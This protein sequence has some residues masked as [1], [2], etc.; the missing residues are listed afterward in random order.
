M[1]VKFPESFLDDMREQGRV[2]SDSGAP[3]LP[4]DEPGGKHKAPAQREHKIQEALFETAAYKEG[5][6][7]ALKLLYAVPNGQ[8]RR[9]QR[10]EPGL[11]S[12]VPDVALP[13]PRPGTDGRLYHGLYLELKR[14]GGRVRPEQRTWLERLR[15]AGYAARVVYGYEEAWTTLI[16]YLDGCLPPNSDQ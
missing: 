4:G 2:A 12:G 16:D 8:Y 6:R 15:A 1:S 14:E 9:G 10:M 7:P 5:E 11:K 13:V 3:S